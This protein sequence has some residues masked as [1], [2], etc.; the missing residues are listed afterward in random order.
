MPP[1]GNVS[2][3]GTSDPAF[4]VASIKTLL[5]TIAAALPTAQVFVASILAMR[6]SIKG[7]L[8]AACGVKLN[9]AIPGLLSANPNFHYV[10]LYENTSTPLVCGD[11]TQQ[12]SIGDGIHP[13]PFG[14]L[15]VASVFSR[16]IAEKYC[17]NHRSDHS[18]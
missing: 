3:T 2:R 14:H 11:N 5:G 13:N 10:P 7:G 12:Y 6:S 16:T 4:A 1:S 18:C 15:R 17:P 8:D 9:A